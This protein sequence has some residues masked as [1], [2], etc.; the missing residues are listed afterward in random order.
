MF[1]MLD[2]RLPAIMI[3]NGAHHL[4]LRASNENDPQSVREARLLETKYILQWI[5]EYQNK[6]QL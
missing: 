6:V 4:D 1:L 3:E 2:I 5:K